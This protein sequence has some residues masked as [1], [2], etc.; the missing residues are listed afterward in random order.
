MSP[1]ERRQAAADQ[2]RRVDRELALAETVAARPLC[3][4]CRF[5]PMRPTDR[6]RCEHFAHWEISPDRKLRIPVTTEQARSVD[7]LCGP[8]ALLFSPYKWWRLAPRWLARQKPETTAW[9]LMLAI[10]G[11]IMLLAVLVRAFL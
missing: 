1:D 3:S 9:V 6:D 4:D 10:L 11:V 5:G 8:E 2:L 7:G